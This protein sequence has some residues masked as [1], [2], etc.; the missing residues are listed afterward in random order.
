MF[1]IFVFG[2]EDRQ[3]APNSFFG[4]DSCVL[5][6]PD[7]FCRMALLAPCFLM[8]STDVVTIVPFVVIEAS[9]KRS[10]VTSIS[11]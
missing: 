4:F 6:S 3:L 2:Q 10:R 5:C 9:D 8:G 7:V 11:F 1:P